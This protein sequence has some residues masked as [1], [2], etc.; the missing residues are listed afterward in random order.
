MKVMFIDS[1]FNRFAINGDLSNTLMSLLALGKP[2]NASCIH[3]DWLVTISKTML[4]VH[5]YHE[6]NLV[7]PRGKFS[8]DYAC[9]RYLQTY[10]A[11]DC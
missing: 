5:P 11:I 4:C 10:K 9:N 3:K 1:P 2:N 7:L 6:I 8:I